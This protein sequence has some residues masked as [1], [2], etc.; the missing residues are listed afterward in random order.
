MENIRKYT[1]FD[2]YIQYIEIERK[3]KG[4]AVPQRVDAW[5]MQ[6]SLLTL[7]NIVVSTARFI[8]CGMLATLMRIRSLQPGQS[9]ACAC[10]EARSLRALPCLDRPLPS[11]LCWG[12]SLAPSETPLLPRNSPISRTRRRTLSYRRD[13]ISGVSLLFSAVSK[14]EL[15]TMTGYIPFPLFFAGYIPGGKMEHACD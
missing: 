9:S 5:I 14:L 4:G 1:Y 13:V 10:V 11:S 6:C 15:F 3:R 8:H 7:P 2:F 12:S